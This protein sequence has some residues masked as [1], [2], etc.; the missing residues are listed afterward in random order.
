[1]VIPHEHAADIAAVARR[2]IAVEELQRVRFIRGGV[3]KE[4]YASGDRY[5]HIRQFS[6]AAKRDSI[7]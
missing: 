6:D 3:P 2:L 7:P 5:G 4:V 1:M